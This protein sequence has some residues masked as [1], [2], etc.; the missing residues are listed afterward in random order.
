MCSMTPATTATLPSATQ[1]T[2]D[3]DVL[4]RDDALLRRQ[5]DDAVDEQER[6]AVRQDALDLDDVERGRRVRRV[7]GMLGD[8]LVGFCHGR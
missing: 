3:G 1:S 8:G 4:Q 5:V 6:V 2:F 7:R